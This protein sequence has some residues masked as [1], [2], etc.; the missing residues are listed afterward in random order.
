MEDKWVP[1]PQ[2]VELIASVSTGEKVSVTY[3]LEEHLRVNALS[4]VEQKTQ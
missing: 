4:K 3:E 2:E 1:D